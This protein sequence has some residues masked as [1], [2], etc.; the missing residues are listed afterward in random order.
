M[1]LEQYHPPWLFCLPSF[2]QIYSVHVSHPKPV[3]IYMVFLNVHFI[4]A[5]WSVINFVVQVISKLTEGRPSHIPYRDSK[6]TR[7]LQSSL[8]GH[9]R[10][11][12]RLYF[13]IDI[14]KC[15]YFIKINIT[16]LIFCGT[17]YETWLFLHFTVI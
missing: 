10:I 4:I 5:L 14:Q 17:K 3:H 7:L 9:G 8:S 2:Q 12:V 15:D 16:M 6:L 13:C 11:S 1:V